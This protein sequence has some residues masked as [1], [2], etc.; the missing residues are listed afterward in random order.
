V[1]NLILS[2]DALKNNLSRY[3]NEYRLISDA[4]DIVD[5]SVINL[6]ISYSISTSGDSNPETVLQASNKSISEY[7][8]IEN[9]QIEQ[10]VILTDIINIIINT[11]GVVSLITLNLDNIA[12]TVDERAYSNVSYSVASNLQQ[13]VLHAPP[14]G[15]FEVKFPDDDII[16]IIS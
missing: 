8:K 15:I 12:G 5:A 16:G 1:D 13:G 6:K 9:F 4:I 2:S 7:F 11:P 3:I 14:G 10:P